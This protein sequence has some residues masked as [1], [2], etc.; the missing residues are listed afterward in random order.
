[1][2]QSPSRTLFESPRK[3]ADSQQPLAFSSRHVSASK[4]RGQSPFG[5]GLL[6]AGHQVLWWR[7]G[8]ALQRLRQR[9]LQRLG[10]CVRVR[11]LSVLRARLAEGRPCSQYAEHHPRVDLKME[12]SRKRNPHLRYL[13]SRISPYPL[14][15]VGRGAAVGWPPGSFRQVA[16]PMSLYWVLRRC[17]EDIGL[18]L[19]PVA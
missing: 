10:A 19:V 17:G 11:L 3:K 18:V 6:G 14:M 15:S 16:C 13:I 2:G 7:G 1:M 8:R 4:L 5:W 12:N 9:L